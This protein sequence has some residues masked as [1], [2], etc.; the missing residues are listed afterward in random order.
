MKQRY[1]KWVMN[2]KGVEIT[3]E[4]YGEV[5]KENF[6]EEEKDAI[7]DIREEILEAWFDAVFGDGKWADVTPQAIKTAVQEWGKA[8]IFNEIE[9]VQ[10]C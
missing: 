1:A 2:Y 7:M 8:E 9:I 4:N 10:V 6:S 5:M 3:S